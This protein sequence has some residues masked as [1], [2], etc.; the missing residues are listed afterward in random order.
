MFFCDT[1]F[2]ASPSA[3]YELRGIH[4]LSVGTLFPRRHDEEL[5]IWGNNSLL[6]EYLR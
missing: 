2:N 1:I 6:F 3:A 5:S 4:L